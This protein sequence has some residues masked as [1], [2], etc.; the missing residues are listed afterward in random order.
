[1]NNFIITTDYTCDLYD[2]FW[3]ENDV[4]LLTMPISVND[5]EYDLDKTYISKIDM[6]NQMREGAVVKTSQVNQFDALQKFDKILSE[7]KDILH[8]CFSSGVSASFDNFAPTVNELKKRY[9]NRKIEV[10]DSLA[11]SCG[12]GLIVYDAIKMQKAGKTIDEIKNYIEKNKLKYSHFFVVQDLA[13]LKRGGRISSIEATIGTILGIKPVLT[14][15]TK[16]KIGVEEK[17]R[18][19]KKAFKALVDATMKN[20]VIPENDFILMCHSDCLEDAKSIGVQLEEKTGLKIKYCD[21]TWLVGAHVG[22]NTIGVFCKGK[23]RE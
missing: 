2:E 23:E 8:I 16:G 21:L 11:G 6:Y 17:V 1:M 12:L 7:G 9:P 19:T 4:P 15:D 22:P 14:L 18:G 13:N 10:V 3:Q 5:K 20:I